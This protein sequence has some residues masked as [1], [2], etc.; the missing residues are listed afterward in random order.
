MTATYS[1]EWS[2]YHSDGQRLGTVG[3][4][5]RGNGGNDGVMSS[6]NQKNGDFQVVSEHGG[7]ISI[8]INLLR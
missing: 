1:G 4:L 7:P 6:T 2:V 5:V 3:T 8:L